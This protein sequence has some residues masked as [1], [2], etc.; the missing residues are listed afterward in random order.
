[1]KATIKLKGGKGSGNFNH[2]GIPGKVGGSIPNSSSAPMT[3]SQKYA[4]SQG[5]NVAYYNK[6]KSIPHGGDLQQYIENAPYRTRDE[7][8]SGIED[9]ADDV[10]TTPKKPLKNASDYEKSSDEALLYAVANYAND[11]P[12]ASAIEVS[13][14]AK[15][16]GVSRNYLIHGPLYKRDSGI[17]KYFN[18]ETRA[19]L[20]QLRIRKITEYGNGYRFDKK[21]GVVS[22]RQAMKAAAKA[23]GYKDFGKLYDDL[24]DTPPYES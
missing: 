8:I 19:D 17:N 21:N 11:N 22:Y 1:M 16:S 23:M 18:Y 9:S 12:G 14:L 20:D 7:F 13:T 10:L 15:Y 2:K 3:E 5:I 4:V 24:I 6:T